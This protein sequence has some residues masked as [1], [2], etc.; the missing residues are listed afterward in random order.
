MHPAYHNPPHVQDVTAFRASQPLTSQR[1]YVLDDDRN[2]SGKSPDGLTL[3]QKP[4]EGFNNT[5]SSS[6]V[7]EAGDPFVTPVATPSED[8]LSKL[9]LDLN[10]ADYHVPMIKDD[11]ITYTQGHA[12]PLQPFDANRQERQSQ[13]V[14]KINSAFE[15][16][17]PGTL[18]RSRQSSDISEGKLFTAIGDKRQPRK[19]QRKKRVSSGTSSIEMA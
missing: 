4:V 19:L 13:V 6:P 1:S 15:I 9:S 10:A 16:L 11:S 18:D 2:F 3:L 7:L 14:R 17:R 8:H 5:K 12:L